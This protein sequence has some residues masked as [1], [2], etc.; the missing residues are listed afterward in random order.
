MSKLFG[1]K[2]RPIIV[3]AILVFV[4]SFPG[5]ALTVKAQ[6]TD[7]WVAQPQFIVR[8][9]ADGPATAHGPAAAAYGP[10]PLTPS[11]IINAYHLTST[12]GGA[13]KTIAIVDAYN[14]PTIAGDLAV[15]S[16][17]FGLPAANFVEHQMSSGISTNSRWAIEISLDVE[18]AHA[19]APQATIL[20][21]EATSN[22]FADLMNAVSYATSY[23]GVV[24]LSMSW[25]GGESSTQLAYDSYFANAMSQHGIVCFASSGDNGAG[26]I[27][28]ST[29][30]YVVAVGGTTLNLGSG[31]TVTSETAWSGSGGGVSALETQPAYQATYGLAYGK[32]STPDVSY[33]ADPN[34]GLYVYDSTPYNGQA[35]WWDVGGTS[36]GSPQ[37]AAIQALGLTA[38]NNNFYQIAK[39]AAYSTDF[40]DIVSGSNGYPAGP[41]YDLATGLGSPLTTTFTAVTTL[42]F[43]ISASPNP[44]TINTANK[45]QGTTTLTINALNG[46]TSTVALTVSAPTGWTAT[47]SPP[48]VTGPGTSTLTIIVPAGQAA[49]T[50]PVTVTGTSGSLVHSVTV[51][52]QVTAPDFSISASPNSLTIRSGSSGTSTV[53]VNA[54]NGFTGTVSLS[55]SAPSGLTTSLTSNSITNSGTSTL[56]I[57]VSSSIRSGTYTVT[58]TGTSGS[59]SHSAT[60]TVRVNR[61][62]G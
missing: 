17:N 49:G 53:T 52:V 34:T 48:S 60:V 21:V 43:A 32:R 5:I 59:L 33:D 45:Q 46:F 62:F 35:G 16:S 51:N 28:P 38:N 20:L 4:V 7:E 42:D 47:P 39:S 8:S 19:I 27:W 55:A 14:D 56:K 13:G 30:P 2:A 44:V 29:S 22:A 3:L 18:W 54:L 50:F 26:V 41:G 1:N 57:T 11:Q 61:F 15:F 10:D 24:A 36:A 23:P 12:T 6:T 9:A 37:W 40:R 31:G 58:V 25:G